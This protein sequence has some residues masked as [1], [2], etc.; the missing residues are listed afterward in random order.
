MEKIYVNEKNRID[1]LKYKF[2][3]GIISKEDLNPDDALL[4][5]FMYQLEIISLDDQ[6]AE[7]NETL[8]EY[9]ERLKNAIDYLKNKK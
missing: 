3:N 6:I 2:E 8:E 4:L 5:S 7:Q 9:K 1:N